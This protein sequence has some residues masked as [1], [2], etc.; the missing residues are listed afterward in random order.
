MSDIAIQVLNLSKCYEILR[1]QTRNDTLR[2]ALAGFPNRINKKEEK[3]EM[4]WALKDVSF[5]VKQGEVMGIIGRNGAGKSTLL[6]ILSR[7]TK[8]FSGEAIIKGRVRALLEVGTGFHPELTGRENIYFNG[9]ILGMKKAEVDRK[10]DEIVAFAETE[11]FLDVPVKRYSSGMY[12]RLAFA[13]AAH[14]EP[15]ILIVDEVLAVGDMLFQQKCIGKITKL[16][17]GGITVIFVTHNLTVAQRL[18]STGILLDKGKITCAGDMEDIIHRYQGVVDPFSSEV[19]EL[20]VKRY[21]DKS[22]L[23]AYWRNRVSLMAEYLPSRGSVVDFGCGEMWLETRLTPAHQYIP[24]DFVKRDQRTILMDLRTDDLSQISGDTAFL[25]GVLEYIPE[26]ISFLSRL[27]NRGFST[28]VMSYCTVEKFSDF[29][30]RRDWGWLSD[31]S[32]LNIIEI[33]T[34]K[35][36]L[37]KVDEWDSNTIFVFLQRG[38]S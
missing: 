16:S 38:L 5:D 11:S 7:I 36:T 31:L 12:V 4:I 3:R 14:L 26:V 37:F 32:A 2:D 23:D 21:A 29:G 8:P 30:Q 1:R 27:A 9:S 6:K 19:R 17:T 10:F 35:Y 18:C 33:M 13:V 34:R 20:T 28:I 22:N 24:V 25:S 15:E